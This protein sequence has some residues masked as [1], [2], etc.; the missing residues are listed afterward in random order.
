MNAREKM[1]AL[2]DLIRQYED[3]VRKAE[4]TLRDAQLRLEGVR[5]AKRAVAGEK[6]EVTSSKR[7]LKNVKQIVLDIVHE[8]GD[9][10]V[11]AAIVLE[12][13]K[14]KHGVDLVRG[15]VSSLLSRLTSEGALLY[16]GTVY[17]PKPHEPPAR[18]E[19][20]FELRTSRSAP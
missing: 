19:G 11:D 12:V 3:E 4:I 14:Q 15:T 2:D 17:R 8:R 18:P 13:A 1:Q 7:R 5:A 10:G 9:Q 16:D 6:V 20:V